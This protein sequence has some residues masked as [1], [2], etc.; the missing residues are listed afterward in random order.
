MLDRTPIVL[1]MLVAGACTGLSDTAQKPDFDSAAIRFNRAS[2]ALTSPQF[3]ERKKTLRS[4]QRHGYVDV[5][6]HVTNRDG[7]SALLAYVRVK[8]RI[9][10]SIRHTQLY[11]FVP[12]IQPPQ[13]SSNPPGFSGSPSPPMAFPLIDDW[14]FPEN[15]WK[16]D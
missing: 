6:G 12:V 4:F 3:E 2:A 1:I 14:T 7:L 10:Y 13:S 11:V 15:P 9:A 5:L 8:S 16:P